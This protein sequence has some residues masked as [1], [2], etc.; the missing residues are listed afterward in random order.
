MMNTTKKAALIYNPN[1]GKGL[2]LHPIILKA[3][4]IIKRK[5]EAT[6][7]RQ[8]LM[9]QVVDHLGNR[10]I[11]TTLFPT[12]HANH[13]TEIALE[14]RNNGYDFIIAAGGDGTINEVVNGMVGG[15]STLAIIPMGTANILSLELDL[16]VEIDE[17]CE[18]IIAGKIKTI[19]LGKVNNRYFTCMAGVGFDAHVINITD[20]KL[21]KVFGLLAYPLVMMREF[22]FYRFKKITLYI[23]DQPLP[24]RGY[25]VVISNGKY[26]A[27]K[28]PLATHAVLDDGLLDITILKH[29]SL[30]HIALY[31]LGFWRN[32]IHTYESVEQFQGRTI[33][34]DKKGNS[35][36]HIDA[37]YL[38]K[39]PVTIT[40]EPQALTVIV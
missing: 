20:S 38:C 18:R 21:K 4:G 34:I 33:R 15:S 25:F 24:R 2:K 31:I 32:K 29:R 30:L 26:Y 37:E 28:I 27:G 7:N 1:S 36:I 23:D 39:A 40:I 17:A 22:L 9:A 16:P 5:N 8:E 19:D 10:G 35:D 3:F 13:A 14:C 6:E 11:T 12:K